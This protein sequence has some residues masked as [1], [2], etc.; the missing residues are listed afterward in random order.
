VLVKVINGDI[1]GAIRK[2]KRALHNDG[3]IKE[4]LRR[5]AYE[6]PSEKKRRRRLDA[7]REHRR[8]QRLRSDH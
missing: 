7:I 6:K 4:V 1:E 3:L 8:Q 5:K 2:M